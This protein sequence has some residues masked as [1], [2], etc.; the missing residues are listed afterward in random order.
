MQD[1]IRLDGNEKKKHY[2]YK[3]LVGALKIKLKTFYHFSRLY[4]HFPFS[5]SGKLQGKLRLHEPWSKSSVRLIESQI[6][7]VKK[8]TDKL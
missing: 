2:T 8:G 4:L 7:G 3:G 5:W 6:K 1:L